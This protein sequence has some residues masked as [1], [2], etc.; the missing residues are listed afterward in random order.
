[1]IRGGDDFDCGLGQTFRH[2]LPGREIRNKPPYPRHHQIPNIQEGRYKDSLLWS[3]YM[4]SLVAYSVY[5]VESCH[6]ISLIPKIRIEIGHSL[7][8]TIN[9][10]LRVFQYLLSYAVRRL[11]KH[12]M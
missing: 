4:G 9:I 3:V 12:F 10:F 6:F 8:T 5:T 11:L 7:L 2:S 1:M